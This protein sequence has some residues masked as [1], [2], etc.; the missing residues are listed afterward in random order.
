MANQSQQQL[1]TV[2]HGS[3]HALTALSSLVEVSV[4]LSVRVCECFHVCRR[5]LKIQILY[6]QIIIVLKNLIKQLL[7]RLC[8]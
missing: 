7:R 3:D 1:N 2:N 6:T 4:C 8:C 5:K